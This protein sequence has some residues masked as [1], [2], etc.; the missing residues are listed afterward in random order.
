MRNMGRQLRARRLERS[1]SQAALASASGV[2]RV[3][4]ARVEGGALQDFRI[5]TIGRLCDALGLELSADP[6]GAKPARA[7]RRELEIKLA[8][9][10]ER[11]RRLDRRRRHAALAARLLAMGEREAAALVARARENV[12]RWRRERLC[13][14]HYVERWRSLLAGSRDRV[15]LSLL[16][17]GEWEDALFQNS[18]WSFAL[19]P[20]TA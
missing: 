11:S 7:G 13:S 20:E 9:E 15:A 1:L 17:P 18:P 10:E 16:E 5:G 4:I 8:R 19:P 2:S 12:E 3:T 14:R 6:T